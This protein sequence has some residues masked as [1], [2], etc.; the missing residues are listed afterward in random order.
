MF[1][2]KQKNYGSYEVI[3]IPN[4][5]LQDLRYIPSNILKPPYGENV[6]PPSG[7]ALPEKKSPAQINGMRAAC[8]L[9]RNT[10]NFAKELV[11]VC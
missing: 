10:L 1:N 5:V 6:L 3:E 9:A 8:S 2:R 4:H 7:P 11:K